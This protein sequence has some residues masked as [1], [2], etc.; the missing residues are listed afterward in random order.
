V[1][2]EAGVAG[3]GLS[4]L[5]AAAIAGPGRFLARIVAG[6]RLAG[7]SDR[8]G[9]GPDAATVATALSALRGWT[10]L[11]LHALI[12]LL[13]VV[14][15]LTLIG[16]TYLV[17]ALMAARWLCGEKLTGTLVFPP[18]LAF[19]GM[20][21]LGTVTSVLPTGSA[22]DL[23]ILTGAA[24]VYLAIVNPGRPSSPRGWALS[25]C[26]AA[27]IVAAYGL[28]QYVT[29]G[30]V[31]S[32]HWYDPKTNPGLTTRVYST[33]GNPNILAEYLVLTIPL[34]LALLWSETRR[35]KRLVFGAMSAGMALC[36]GLTFSRGGWLGMAV[37]VVAGVA[38]ID[39][40]ALRLVPIGAIAGYLLLPPVVL[41][42]IYTVVNLADSSNYYR[43]NIWK[44][45]LRLIG[46]FWPTGVGL[47]YRPFMWV[48]GNYKLFGQVAWH[49]H[50]LY[51]EQ[52]AELGVAG[53]VLFIWL[54]VRVLAAGLRA[55]SLLWT[56]GAGPGPAGL[57]E[58]G[59][60]GEPAERRGRMALVAAGLAAVAGILF[61]GLVE[62]IF[63]LPTVIITF[64]IVAGLMVVAG[65]TIRTA[66]GVRP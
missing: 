27:T 51:L 64:W 13:P 34:A 66:D 54:M 43:L 62:N 37:A 44:S 39:P 16:L 12:W 31:A 10:D 5:R 4:R 14:A 22:R 30:A 38:V 33:F 53:L 20:G 48:Y 3:I 11:T 46:D 65:R 50:N 29:G 59:G 45:T 55:R 32:G 21:A 7:G 26:A 9:G 61:Y 2:Y 19:L 52:V 15:P 47:G 6:S 60:A 58:T 24:A 57:A 42:R 40:R 41:N 35:W 1:R 23:A 8:A 36:L 28:L 17:L 25:L 49:S 63:Y 56:G 18:M